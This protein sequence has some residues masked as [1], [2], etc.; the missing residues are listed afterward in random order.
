MSKNGGRPSEG[1][2]STSSSRL[3]NLEE[4]LLEIQEISRQ[5]NMKVQ[6]PVKVANQQIPEKELAKQ[7]EKKKT[8]GI[9]NYMTY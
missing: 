4:Q 3:K 1:K 7:P 9:A 5:S 2:Q 8:S 6:R